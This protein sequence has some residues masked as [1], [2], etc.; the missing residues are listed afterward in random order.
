[1]KIGYGRECF[2]K[3]LKPDSDILRLRNYSIYSDGK[4]FRMSPRGS[5]SSNTSAQLLYSDQW[6]TK[7]GIWGF[8][9]DGDC[10]K[11]LG[12]IMC[13]RKVLQNRI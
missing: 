13:N 5:L 11:N 2:L 12:A 4:V 6:R 1:M 9:L 8:P 10:F 7:A 3:P